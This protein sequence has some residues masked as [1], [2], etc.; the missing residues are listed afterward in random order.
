MFEQII[1]VEQD[2]LYSSGSREDQC[3]SRSLGLN[4]IYCTPQVLGFDQCLSRSLGLNEIYCT[5]PG[6]GRINA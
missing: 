2:L 5:A 1:G 6:L 4:E 3:L